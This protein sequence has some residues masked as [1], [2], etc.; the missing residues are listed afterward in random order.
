MR[1]ERRGLGGQGLHRVPVARRDQGAR[2][3]PRAADAEHVGQREEVGGV[4]QGH[5]A[6]G[7]E[8]Q[9]GKGAREARSSATPP[10]G[11]AGNSLRVEKPRSAALIASLAVATP[12]RRGMRACSAM[13]ASRGLSPGETAKTAPASALRSRSS[14]LRTVPVPTMAPGTWT[15]TRCTARSASAV[16]RVNSSTGRPP[17]TR[18]SASAT[19]S[20]A[21]STTS[22]G[23]T[24][25]AA[26]SARS[27]AWGPTSGEG[28]GELRERWGGVG[29][30]RG[31]WASGRVGRRAALRAWAGGRR[32]ARPGPPARASRRRCCGH[33]QRRFR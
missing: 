6:G 20:P 15:A 9:L 3:H 19:A 7:A 12:G 29:G 4:L 1:S 23:I 16:R 2:G 27:P 21:S 25:A 14:G 13:R 5:A 28:I 8:A 30:D 24:G 22:T 17:A 33:S 11:T 10:T 26:S 32:R 31:G 18:A